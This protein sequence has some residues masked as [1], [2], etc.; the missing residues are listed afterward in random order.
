MG[1]Q[2]AREEVIARI[3]A[4]V[5][6]G[7][8]V[9]G[10]GCSCGLI[11]R[12]AEIGGADVVLVYSTGK[13]RLM[14]LPTTRMGDSNA[15]TL[16]LADEIW[17]ATADVPIIGGVD[18]ADPFRLDMERLLRQFSDKGFSGVI[19]FPSIVGLG[20][21]YRRRRDKVGLGFQREV[22]LV[23]TARRMGLFTMAYV[24]AP[25]DVRPFIEAGVDCVVAH[26]GPTEGGLQG[27][28]YEN[29][30]DGAIDQV[31]AIVSAALEL[32]PA[33]IPLAHGGPF[34]EP[35]DTSVLYTRTRVVGFVGASS[36]E[37]IPIERAVTD[38][39]KRFKG[40][41]AAGRGRA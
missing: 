18:P 9:V 4:V 37:R 25:A 34:A 41:P 22:E 28:K 15:I 17:N 27:V 32:D 7:R 14:G 2:Y 16:S 12:C 35:E 39:V 19:N 21:Y 8:P 36:I 29:T 20:D 11:A 3:K 30:L 31:N 13:S 26:V 40:V 23:A 33:T 6:G 24:Y 5:A 10:A 38:V 1:R